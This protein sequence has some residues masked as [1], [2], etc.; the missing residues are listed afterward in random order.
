VLALTE[1]QT[2]SEAHVSEFLSLAQ[3]LVIRIISGSSVEC[4]FNPSAAFDTLTL[5]AGG[6]S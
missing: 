4:L 3:F 6:H 2:D 1:L 5:T